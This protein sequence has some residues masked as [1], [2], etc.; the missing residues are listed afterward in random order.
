MSTIYDWSLRASD[1]TR[2]DDLI[3]WSE[4]QLPS[5]INNSA[6]G[7]M[8][9]VREY[10][11]D[12]GG[13]LEGVVRV[14]NEQQTSAIT[15]QTKS[16]FSEYKND[17]VIGFK[18]NGKNVGATTVSLN[19]LP[20]KPVYKATELGAIPLL[21]GEIQQ[22]CIYSLAY[23]ESLAGWHLLNPTPVLSPTGLAN[24]LYPAGFI[25]TFAM[26]AIPNGWLL[27]DGSAYS[28]SYYSDLFAAIGTTWGSGDGYR[29][30]N[31]P[32]LRG[33]FLRGFDDGRNIDTGRSFASVQQDLIQSH[34][35]EGH[36]IS[37]SQPNNEDERYW[38][39]NATVLWGHVLDEDEK[40]RVATVS[41]IREENIRTYDILAVPMG[42]P[43]S[44]DLMASRDSE[45]ETRPI[46]V[47]VVFAIKT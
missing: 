45:S 11:S 43:H 46:N 41:R 38:H 34:Q 26:Q 8:Q 12:T 42:H 17:I 25:G 24:A 20:A 18:A 36:R 33:M 22:G 7:M 30:F 3:D 32:D 39:G 6:R 47:S 1:N 44:Q 16:L 28:R 9:R 10:L 4:G 13:T 21:G 35:H 23:D 40:S 2:A 5:T 31:I 27:C 15:L 19:N 29:T 37:V 14:D